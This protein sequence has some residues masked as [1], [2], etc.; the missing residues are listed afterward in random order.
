MENNG[1]EVKTGIFSNSLIWLQMAFVTFVS[2]GFVGFLLIALNL[3][4]YQWE[5]IPKSFEIWMYL[6]CG[7]FFFFSLVFVLISKGIT[8]RY[9][10][11]EEGVMQ[12]TLTTYGKFMK[13]F[14]VLALL[15][16]G[17]KGIT[18]AGAT[19]L[20]S[21]RE[22]IFSKWNEILYVEYFPK[23]YEI[24]L[25]NS[26]RTVIQIICNDQNYEE[27]EKKVKTNVK[28]DKNSESE[29][30]GFS[31]IIQTFLTLILGILL[32]PRLPIHFVGAFTIPMVL[33]SLFATWSKTILKKI[34][35]VCIIIILIAGISL[36]Y[37]YGEVDFSRQGSE[38][39][40]AI[41]L[42]SFLY[43]FA[44][45]LKALLQNKK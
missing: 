36:A 14:G 25:K 18:A 3:F 8:T 33:F 37:Y 34:S 28:I 11:S 12:E 42:I 9:T 41:E 19:L 29:K 43:F 6:Y 24:R 27:I 22:V 20:A 17:R 31:K 32:L 13:I 30:S 2:S 38:Y 21:S 40:F 1:W 5:A 39:A 16:G 44:L 7:M 23:K 26:F 4:E 45:S 35:G 10:V 15:F